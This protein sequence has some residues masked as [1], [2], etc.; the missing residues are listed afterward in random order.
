MSPSRSGAFGSG[1]PPLTPRLLSFTEARARVLAAA[2]ALPPESVDVAAVRGRALRETIRA[3]HALPPFD[4][5]AMDGYA[6]RAS[7]VARATIAQPVTLPVTMV[8]PAGMAPALPLAAGAA[9][10]IMTGAPLPEGADAIVAFEDCE[11]LEGSPERVRFSATA[12]PRHH[13]RDAG[14][15]IVA[16][17]IALHAGRE[18]S[19]YDLALLVALGQSRV[20]VGRRPRAAIVSTGDELLGAGDELRAGAIR[21]SNSPMLH[22]LLEEA[23]C[24]VVSVAHAG[25]APGEALGAIRAALD[26]ADVTLSIGGVSAGDFDPVKGDLAGIPGAELWRVAMKPG[27]PQAFATANGK[28]FFGLP[29]NPA[30]VACVFETLVRPAL[31]R[32]QGFR[33]LTR[34]RILVRLA[35]AIESREG[36]A[37]FVRARLEW[38]YGDWWA[39]PCGAQV[40]GHL[41]PQSRADVLLAIPAEREALAA[42]ET[43][44]AFLLRW[45]GRG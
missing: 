33:R 39:N 20:S 5:S 25:D 6:V 38:H 12:A 16:G 40:S 29:G 32:L 31:R 30:S 7:D 15:D 34:P 9:A 1:G 4:N 42:G 8:I 2:A 10:R 36:R 26:R 22:A 44:A 24:E 43:V 41:G 11:R 17:A 18:L 37:D 19:A 14:A 23:G 27:R 3:P 45:P 21:D 35:T 28:L 13:V